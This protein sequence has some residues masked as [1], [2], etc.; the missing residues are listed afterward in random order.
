MGEGAGSGGV[1]AGESARAV[2]GALE[3]RRGGAGGA[4]AGVRRGGGVRLVGVPGSRQ[5]VG[6]GRGSVGAAGPG[7]VPLLRVLRDPACGARAHERGGVQQAG[8]AEQRVRQRRRGQDVD[9]RQRRR[10]RSAIE[11]RDELRAQ[12]TGP[13]LR[14]GGRRYGDVAVRRSWRHLE[15]HQVRDWL[16]AQQHLAP[17]G[18]ARSLLQLRQSPRIGPHGGPETITPACQGRAG[19]PRFHRD[20]HRR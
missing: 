7:A 10:I 8:S 15:T 3:V 14:R 16:C 13:H 11:A 18:A 5:D 20:D 2:A 1:E 6:P 17:V 19:A 12:R 4:R 9:H